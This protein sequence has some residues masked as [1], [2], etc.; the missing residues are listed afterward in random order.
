MAHGG[1]RRERLA[2]KA[3]GGNALEPARVA[4]L[5]RGVAQEGHARVLGRHAA[6]VVRHA[7][8]GHAAVP[9]LHGHVPGA[10]VKGVFHQL[11][12]HGGGS[13]HHLARGDEI[14][15]VGG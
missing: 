6:A 15:H 1:D 3:E 13:L 8:I 11:L 10:G 12:H 9:Q 5:A 4:Q 14:R 2:A 7:Q